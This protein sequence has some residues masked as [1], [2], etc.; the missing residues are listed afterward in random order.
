MR[1]AANLLLLAAA[2]IT[3]MAIYADTQVPGR[4]TR[5]GELNMTSVWMLVALRWLVLTAAFSVLLATHRLSSWF[6]S[7]FLLGALVIVGLIVFEIAS[8]QL[9]YN[10]VSTRLP[11]SWHLPFYLLSALLPACVIAG[12]FLP[13]RA[14]FFVAIAG[15][16][17]ANISASSREKS[18]AAERA[19]KQ[20]TEWRERLTHDDV[21][22]LVSAANPLNEPAQLQAVFEQ[23]YARPNWAEETAKLLDEGGTSSERTWS[24]RWLFASF[25]L[26]RNPSALNDELRERCWIAARSL[27]GWMDRDLTDHQSAS[28][29]DAVTLRAAVIGLAGIPGPVRERHR[30][31]F[32]AAREVLQRHSA[33][34]NNNFEVPG[35]SAWVAAK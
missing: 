9:A 7:G 16:L 15:A 1:I 2:A 6:S 19:A 30:A 35:E 34:L 20:D 29:A 3:A 25:A 4:Y 33:S 27:T 28:S 24:T 32:D 5:W 22:A 11:A 17:V 31:D 8:G 13:S 26:C 23:L 18:Y 10:A 14:L 12:G 21:S